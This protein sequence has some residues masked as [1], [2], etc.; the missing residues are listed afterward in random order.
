[1]YAGSGGRQSDPCPPGHKSLCSA[2][3]ESA[4]PGGYCHTPIV[5]TRPVKLVV[6]HLSPTRSLIESDVSEC[7]TGGFPYLMAGD[8]NAKHTDCN[9]RLTTAMGSLIP[10]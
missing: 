10:V 4:V 8:L 3:L 9:S 7:P 2:S 6:A 5:S 1:M